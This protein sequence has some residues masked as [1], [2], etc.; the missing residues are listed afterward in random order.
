MMSLGINWTQLALSSASVDGAEVTHR[1]LEPG[2]WL[3]LEF[4]FSFFLFFSFSFFF[5]FFFFFLL[6]KATPATYIGSQAS[7]RV[8]AYTRAT[9]TSDLSRVCNLHHSSR[10]CRLLNPLSGA[11]DG[12][13][14]LMIPSRI[15]FLC[16][17]MGTPGAGI[18]KIT[19]PP[20]GPL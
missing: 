15:R 7:G 1:T 19:S 3:G 17:M 12:T 9:A 8:G 10:H 4:Y 2:P 14:N 11:R 20:P 6:F 18:F 5:F 16:S 13:C